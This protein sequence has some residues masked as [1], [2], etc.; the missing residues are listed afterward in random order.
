MSTPDASGVIRQKTIEP[1]DVVYTWC[2]VAWCDTIP[3]SKPMPRSIY[4]ELYWHYI[5]M[6]CNCRF[7]VSSVDR[8]LADLA[9]RGVARQLSHPV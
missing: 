7:V 2:G 8:L 6:I 4:D 1:S 5:Q 3:I 9:Q